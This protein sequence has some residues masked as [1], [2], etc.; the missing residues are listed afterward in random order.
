MS[1][2]PLILRE[3]CGFAWRLEGRGSSGST[4]A[5]SEPSSFETQ[6]QAGLLLRMRNGRVFPAGFR[7]LPSLR[8]PHPL[9][10]IRARPGSMPGWSRLL[11]LKI[12]ALRCAP[13]GMT[14]WG[15]EDQASPPHPEEPC[16]FAWRLEG[17]GIPA[18]SPSGPAPP[19]SFET[20]TQAGLLLR[21][22]GGRVFPAGSGVYHLSAPQSLRHPGLDPGSSA[23]LGSPA[24]LRMGIPALRC[25]PAGMTSVGG[26][27]QRR[28]APPPSAAPPHAPGKVERSGTLSGI[29]HNDAPRS[30]S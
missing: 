10:V 8:T 12:P 21:M 5:A 28:A 1:V 13:A 3:T 19:S 15:G 22:R 6:T 25:A 2:F 16:G 14:G 27:I 29:Q 4:V 23:R 26:K 20:Q 7:R 9:S 18:G 11:G 24:L 17:R 30:G